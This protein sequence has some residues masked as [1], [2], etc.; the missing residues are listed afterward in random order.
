M[1]LFIS[2]KDIINILH[3]SKEIGIVS[4]NSPK[5]GDI[6]ALPLTLNEI[7]KIKN[8]NGNKINMEE[9]TENVFFY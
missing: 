9:L 6:S 3:S 8:I 7:S 1:S 2:V 4:E 5:K